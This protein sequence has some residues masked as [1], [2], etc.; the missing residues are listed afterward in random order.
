M[1]LVR[2]GLRSSK[3]GSMGTRMKMMVVYRRRGLNGRGHEE[4]LEVMEYSLTG[5]GDG[6]SGIYI[7]PNSNNI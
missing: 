3:G 7:Y 5:Q 6:N 2:Q 1:I 4:F